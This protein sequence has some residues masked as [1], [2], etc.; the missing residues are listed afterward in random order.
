MEGGRRV[1]A[2]VSALVGLMAVAAGAFGAHAASDPVAKE[3][4][5]TGAQY[6]GLHALAAL[7]AFAALPTLSGSAWAGWL[8]ASGALLFGGSLD[9][10]AVGAPRMVGVITPVGGLLMMAGWLVLA[11]GALRRR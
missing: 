6:Q 7:V 5:R 1:G 10:L 3:L 4:L 2:A 9:L 11:L 8:L